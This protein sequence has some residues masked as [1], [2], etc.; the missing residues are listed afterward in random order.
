MSMCDGGIRTEN[1][2]LGSDARA[3]EAARKFSETRH[4]HTSDDQLNSVFSG[5][6][7]ARRVEYKF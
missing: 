1:E 2:D 5:Q 6:K 3:E 7:R 4:T